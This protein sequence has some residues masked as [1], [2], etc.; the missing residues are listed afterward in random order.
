[1]NKNSKILIS[2]A[3]GLIGTQLINSLIGRGYYNI[4]ILTRAFKNNLNFTK[5]IQ[6]IIWDPK[7][8]K[9]DEKNLND[10]DIV[11]NLVGENIADGL[12]TKSKKQRLLDSR[13]NSTQ[14][15]I[16]S[17][18]KQKHKPKKFISSSA[19]G[20]YGDCANADL[21][22]SSSLGEGFLSNLCHQW[23]KAAL[24]HSISGMDSYCLRTGLVLSKNGGALQKMLTPFKLGLG[25]PL[26]S[27]QQY[28]SWI[29][30]DDLINQFI[31][32]MKTDSKHQIFNAVSP[33]PVTNLA[34]SKSLANT[35]HRPCLFTIPKFV[36]KTVLGDLSQILLDS[37]KVYPKHFEHEEFKFK[38]THLADALNNILEN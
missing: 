28:M 10:I 25:G 29:H 8:S 26:G 38:F 16:S 3:T 5:S 17:L 2:G 13:V 37:Q 22:E 9:I 23:E 18:A 7:S 24:D 14:L 4:F 12:W 32:V 6:Q 21:N 11:F 36:L 34:F 15:I 31:F 27:G 35:L 20:I 30:M 19:I 33:N 1:M